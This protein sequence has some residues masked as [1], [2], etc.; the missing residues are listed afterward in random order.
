MKCGFLKPLLF[1]GSALVIAAVG[2]VQVNAYSL[3]K[4]NLTE[5]I[6]KKCPAPKPTTALP[7]LKPIELKTALAENIITADTIYQEKLTVPSLWW[8]DEQFGGKLLD[9]WIAYVGTNETP[10]RVDLIVN[11]QLWSLLTYL[12]R[13]RFLNQF[14]TIARNY[15]YNVRVFSRQGVFLA[16]YTCAGSSESNIC[17]IC[18]EAGARARKVGGQ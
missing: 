3:E 1:S 7:D 18:L 9:N 2:L 13:Y 8:A 16:A 15:G 14:G 10:P 5:I 17:S 11:R 12:E 4:Q 6:T